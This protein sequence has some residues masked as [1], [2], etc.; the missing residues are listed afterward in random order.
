MKGTPGQW[1]TV[2]LGLLFPKLDPQTERRNF[3]RF[4]RG[5]GN[6]FSGLVMFS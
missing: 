5:S 4:P 2:D 1:V 6:P 3:Q